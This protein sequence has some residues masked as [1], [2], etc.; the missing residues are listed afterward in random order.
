SRLANPTA[1][2]FAPDGRIFVAEKR[3]VV[4][5]FDSLTDTAPDI[6]TDIRTKVHNYWDR[7]L[8]GLAVDPK[9][10]TGRPYIY[11]LYTYDGDIGGAAP[12]WGQP[13]TDS[14]PGTTT[15]TSTVSGR[16]SRLTISGNKAIEEKVLI[17]DWHAQY[18]SHSIGDLNFGP[19]GYLYAS[20]G[21]GADFNK[22]DYGQKNAFNDPIREGGALRS[23]DMLTPGDRTGLGG[24]VIRIDPETGAAAPN[25]PFAS[26]GDANAKR[27]IATGLRNPFRFVFRPGTNEIFIGETGSSLHEEINRITS[28]TDSKAENFGWPAYE[29]REKQP[30]YAAAGI[31]LVEKLYSDP[32]SVTMP[33][34]TYAHDAKIVTGSDEPL[35]GGSPSGLAFYTGNQYPKGFDGALFFTDYA[36]KRIFVI[37]RGVNGLP[38][39][40]TIKT[41]RTLQAGAVDLNI[42]PDGNL[43]YAEMLT[44][45]IG[46]IVLGGT[47]IT[48]PPPENSPPTTPSMT[49]PAAKLAGAIIGTL[50]AS[51]NSGNTRDKVFDGSLATYFDAP[52]DNGAWAGLDL[53]TARKVTQ[54]AFAPRSGAAAAMVG[55]RFQASNDGNFASGVVDLHRVAAAPAEGKLTTVNVNAAGNSYRYVRYIGPD[56]ADC[57]IAEAQFF[58]GNG[59]SGTYYNNIDF[60][61]TN[62]TRV[63]PT[64]NFNWGTGSPGGAIAAD[65]FSTRWTGALQALESGTY[66]FRATTADGVRLS[67]NGQTLFD[68]LTPTAA[69]YSGTINLTAGSMHTV[70][71]RFAEDTGDAAVK[72][73]WLR[74]GKTTYE[75]VPTTQLFSTA[76]VNNQPPI[77]TINSPTTTLNWRVGDSINFAGGATDN[78]GKTLPASRLVWTLVMMHGNEIS[79][80]THEHVIET[81]VGVAGGSLIAPEHEYPSWLELRLSATDDA[82]R[83]TTLTRRINPQTVAI[84]LASD[85]P[86][87]PLTLNNA[88]GNGSVT[89]T[90]MNGASASI[91]AAA[92]FVSDGKTY[93]FAGWSNGASRTHDLTASASATYTARYTLQSSTPSTPTSPEPTT[94]PLGSP[95]NLTAAPATTGGIQLRWTDNATNEVGYRIERRVGTA[96]WVQMAVIGAYSSYRDTRVTAGTTYEYRVRAHRWD[97]NSSYSNTAAAL[98]DGG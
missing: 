1:F 68:K 2:T 7:G 76:P 45:R 42:G 4:K 29:G 17:H 63:D 48:T 16:L 23:Q 51:G 80:T 38:D 35:G 82:G 72:L 73:E 32:A 65:T 67:I 90:L 60:Q 33:W 52:V 30:A 94:S 85:V 28:A 89:Q 18:P 87:A 20:G 37:Y 15:G 61:G 19:D 14:D 95:T 44:G 49:T 22:V 8:L 3:G 70:D 46:R 40:T 27:I 71:L 77:V 69:S 41:F 86:G 54:I 81:F 55:G 88:S 50:G 75:V 79:N 56:G 62:F 58:A 47:A 31:P 66:T 53:W 97:V 13:N 39:P 43:Y 24:T 59:L 92:Q 74:P 9:F 36:R 10:T 21:E 34:F 6:V 78:Q 64:I 11:V 96:S 91:S 84:K 5:V 93:A 12:K 25:N 26:S 98:V 83:S 57:N